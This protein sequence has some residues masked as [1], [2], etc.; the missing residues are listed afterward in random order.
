MVLTVIMESKSSLSA[1]L[2]SI[3]FEHSGNSL[4]LTATANSL[5]M[6]QHILLQNYM[7]LEFPILWKY[8]TIDHLFLVTRARDHLIRAI[9][10]WILAPYVLCLLRWESVGACGLCLVPFP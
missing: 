9:R 10:P 6:Y 5:M 7:T 3:R 1:D 4:G 8:Q 2:D